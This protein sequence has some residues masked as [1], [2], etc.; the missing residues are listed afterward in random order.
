MSP[1]RNLAGPGTEWPVTNEQGHSTLSLRDWSVTLPAASHRRSIL[2]SVTL[3]VPAGKLTGLVGESGSGKS[4]IG[5]SI[6]GL[7][8]PGA[9]CSG[10]ITYAGTE[11]ASL[12]PRSRQRL[13]GKTIGLVSQ[14]ALA[15]L[16][17]RMRIRTQLKQ[18]LR[19]DGQS[20]D[21]LLSAV[22]LSDPRIQDS[23]PHEISG[24]QR[25][26]VLIALALAQAPCILVADEPTTALDVTLQSQIMQLLKRLVTDLGLGVLFISH[27]IGLVLEHCTY[28][29]VL[30]A[31]QLA[32]GAPPSAIRGW[33]RH[34]YTRGLYAS[35]AALERTHPQG[36]LEDG[37]S[38]TI[39][40]PDEFVAGCRF[41]PRC[42][43]AEQTCYGNRPALT[44][45]D[46]THRYACHFPWNSRERSLAPM[47]SE[48]LR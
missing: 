28:V 2:D 31:G 5:K 48:D 39:S 16:N 37:L 13:L 44:P 23:Y 38:G 41:A 35:A 15:A 42:P 10:S 17:P 20:I 33:A 32:E 24:G 36:P 46:A 6:L 34:W 25:Q 8:P 45:V 29:Y 14:D 26:R 22:G 9:R 18:V 19:S 47:S 7:L 40:P 3:D 1:H 30:Y 11:L 43:A 27:D 4:M 21:E 12:T